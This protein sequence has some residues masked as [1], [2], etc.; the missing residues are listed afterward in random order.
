LE[1]ITRHVLFVRPNYFV[2][3][4]N[5]AAN[6]VHQYEWM[7][8]F[9]QSVSVEG[10]W[11]RGEAGDG[12]ILGIRV[13]APQPFDFHTGDD[14]QPYIRLEPK[15]P[16][17][18]VRFINLLYPT[19]EAAWN[20]RPHVI[21][22]EDTGQVALIR[23]QMN[24]GSSQTD[25]IVITYV[26][27]GS[28]LGVGDYESDGQVALIS[29][30]GNNHLKKIFVYGGTFLNNQASGQDLV[31]NLDRATAFEAIYTGQTVAVSGNIFTRVTL[32]APQ[33]I[34]L[35]LNGI[36]W[37]FSREG[38]YIIFEAGLI[39]LPIVMKKG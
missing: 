5:V 22:M 33:V 17:A 12:Q 20:N 36:P 34:Q 19:D 39:Y 26:Q 31:T 14:G 1:D 18:D 10:N 6:S 27:P 29:K 38:D 37:L 8:H 23:V 9:G 21:T 11:V 4:D 25:D 16:V 7:A 32:Y 24:D 15:I 13:A 35:I 28:V 30:T 3:L 2:M